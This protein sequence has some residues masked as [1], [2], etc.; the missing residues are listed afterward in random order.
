ME[1]LLLELI[2]FREKA[3]FTDT[4]R[5]RTSLYC[6]QNYL[7][8]R[9]VATKIFAMWN[10][11]IKTADCQKITKALNSFKVVFANLH[12]HFLL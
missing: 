4:D 3:L 12:G 6:L 1:S 5:S 11:Q 10:T 8:C 7:A 2:Y 9:I